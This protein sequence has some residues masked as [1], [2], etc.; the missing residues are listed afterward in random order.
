MVPPNLAE[1]VAAA[2]RLLHES[3]PIAERREPPQ[4]T[5]PRVTRIER[6]EEGNLALIYEENKPHQQ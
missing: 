4:S 5:V 2:V 6:D 3:A 1:Q